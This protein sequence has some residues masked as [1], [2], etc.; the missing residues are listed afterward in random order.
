MIGMAVEAERHEYVVGFE[1]ASDFFQKSPE[2]WFCPSQLAVGETEE[3][4]VLL[5]NPQ[6]TQSCLRFATAQS[7]KVR[8]N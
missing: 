6:Q 4:E 3:S 5:P 7:N 8:G 2:V 1:V